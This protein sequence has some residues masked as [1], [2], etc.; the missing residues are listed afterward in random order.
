MIETFTSKITNTLAKDNAMY[1][2]LSLNAE[3]RLFYAM[4]Q[5]PLDDLLKQPSPQSVEF[6]LTFS[7]EHKTPNN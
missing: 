4:L 2:D 6:I 5:Q 7:K 3:D 1:D